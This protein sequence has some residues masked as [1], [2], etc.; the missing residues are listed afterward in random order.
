MQLNFDRKG[1]TNHSYT[2]EELVSLFLKTG[3]NTYIGILYVRCSVHVYR[4]CLSIVR[5]P[6]KAQDLTHDIFLKVISRLDSFSGRAQFST[7]LSRVTFNYCMDEFKIENRKLQTSRIWQSNIND[8]VYLADRA[9]DSDLIAI[10]EDAMAALP[11][12]ERIL[13]LMRY[14]QDISVR[15]IALS[16]QITESAVKMRLMRSR[17]KLRIRCQ[18]MCPMLK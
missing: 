9:E 11:T 17:N 8:S 13:M 18:S 1:L 14:S 16:F 15:D 3:Q 6:V 2:N 5:D 4:Q 10:L 7:W 12:E